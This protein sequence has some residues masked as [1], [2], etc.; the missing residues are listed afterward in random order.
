LIKK[1]IDQE[2]VE[3]SD[4]PL[5]AMA[6]RRRDIEEEEEEEITDIELTKKLLKSGI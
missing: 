2:D 6:V 4:P 3:G 5:E 1:N